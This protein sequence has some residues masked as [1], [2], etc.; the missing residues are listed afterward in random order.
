[1][2]QQGIDFQGRPT[3]DTFL[4][5]NNP[6]EIIEMFIIDFR[7]S[8]GYTENLL[9]EEVLYVTPEAQSF[10]YDGQLWTRAAIDFEP[11]LLEINTPIP[12]AKLRLSV[13]DSSFYYPIT[14]LPSLTGTG[15]TRI[16]TNRIFLDDIRINYGLTTDPANY[17]D[18]EI[19]TDNYVIQYV[20]S[21]DT[22]TFNIIL[23][24][25]LGL[26]GKPALRK[27]LGIEFN[28]SC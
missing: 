10:N 4:M 26:D 6:P 24:G 13:L 28:G 17:L 14:T 1:M 16:R 21:R 5:D 19:K 25:T 20:Q 3:F 2:F 12:S 22:E 15:V 27:I 11:P 23:D 18:N 9:A 8:I 7:T